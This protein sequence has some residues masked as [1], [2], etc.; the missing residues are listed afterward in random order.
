[1]TAYLPH[2]SVL[3][4]EVIENLLKDI[5][6]EEECFFV[7]FTYGAGGHSIELLKRKKNCKLLCFDQDIE[8]FDNAQKQIAELNLTDRVY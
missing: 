7:D 6:E 8:A 2:K 3:L 5:P 4:N 1:M